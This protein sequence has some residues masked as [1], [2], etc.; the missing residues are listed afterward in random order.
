MN[1]YSIIWLH[2]IADFFLQNDKMALNKSSSNKWLGIHVAV[3]SIPFLW[4]F[5]WKYALF[6]GVAHFITDWISSRLAKKLWMDGERHWFF[7][8]LGAD[9]AVHMTCLFGSIGLI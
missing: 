9:Q 4:F 5:G 1:L 7:V 8:V 3:Y 2:F 6:N